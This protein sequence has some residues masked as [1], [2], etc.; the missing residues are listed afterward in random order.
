[1][2]LSRHHWVDETREHGLGGVCGTH[3]R[4]GKCTDLKNSV[5][6]AEG[7]RGNECV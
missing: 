4:W 6:C 1:M 3:G 7:K 5:K 2:F